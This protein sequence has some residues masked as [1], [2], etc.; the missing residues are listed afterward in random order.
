MQDDDAAD[1]N[2][3]DNGDFMYVD[4]EFIGEMDNDDRPDESDDFK[5]LKESE[6]SET[7]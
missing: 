5:T 2:D 7:D 6:I 1:D 4:D 3:T